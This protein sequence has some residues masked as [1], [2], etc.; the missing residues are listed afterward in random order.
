MET[1]THGVVHSVTRLRVCLTEEERK[2]AKGNTRRLLML[3]VMLGP[4]W[5]LG[6][7]SSYF[8]SILLM[9]LFTILNSI[10]GAMIFALLVI[11]RKKRRDILLNDIFHIDVMKEFIM[12][13]T[14]IP[15]LLVF[16]RRKSK[17]LIVLNGDYDNSERTMD[18]SLPSVA[19]SSRQ[20][21]DSGEE[22]KPEQGDK[23][24]GNSYDTYPPSPQ[25]FAKVQSMRHR[26]GFGHSDS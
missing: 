4:T 2:N 7:I 3:T 26:D 10:Q 8:G 14:S 23:Q 15:K 17:D 20:A 12:H 19:T 9:G 25:G 11:A 1:E 18:T 13:R 5:L 21:N 22:Y 6:F 24:F 16:R